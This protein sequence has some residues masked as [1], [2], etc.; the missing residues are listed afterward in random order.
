MSAVLRPLRLKANQLARAFDKY[1]M[2]H[3][4]QFKAMALEF[5][6]LV[7]DMTMDPC[8]KVVAW[9]RWRRLA[10]SDKRVYLDMVNAEP[11]TPRRRKR[12]LDDET[13]LQD[14]VM[15]AWIEARTPPKI[16][17]QRMAQLG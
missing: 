12:V 17:A 11:L 7:P 15:E 10:D 14:L 2:V 5:I 4:D 13:L 6:V 9:Q 1:C 8:I 3:R 16:S